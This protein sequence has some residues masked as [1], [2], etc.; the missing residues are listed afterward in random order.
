MM[1]SSQHWKKQTTRGLM[2]PRS[3]KLKAID[4]AFVDYENA[5]KRNQGTTQALTK[6]FDALMDW[7][8]KKGAQWR[9]STRNSKLEVGGKGTVEALLEQLIAKNP[10]FKVKAAPYLAKSAPPPPPLMQHGQK[11]QFK[12]EDG[13]WYEIPVQKEENSCGPCSIRIVIKQVRN[14]EVDEDFLRE[15]VEMV[16]EGGAYG[17]SLG[18]GGVLQ[19]G[20][21]HDWSPSGGGTWLVPGALKSLHPPIA[22]MQGTAV[23][24]LLKSSP[25]KPAIGVVAWDG[26]GLHYV[27]AVGL[28]KDK[29]KLK[30]LDPFYGL[31]YAPV[32]GGAPG[33][34][35]PQVNGVAQGSASWHPWVCSV[36]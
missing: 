32:A 21:A 22:C 26:G 20:G 2:T 36:S 23:A 12:D 6:L 34:Y 24:D 7:V 27:V 3:K 28:S 9:N 16:E 30:I 35:V 18:S 15:L 4:D 25:S 13:R 1:M 11:N 31:Q 33:K 5:V 8:G 19:T 29:S 10:A 17:G 14:T